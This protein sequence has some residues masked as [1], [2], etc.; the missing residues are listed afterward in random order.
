MRPFAGFYFILRY[1]LIVLHVVSHTVILTP[2]IYASLTLSTSAVVIA[3]TKPYKKEYMNVLDTLLLSL[4][5]GIFHLLSTDYTYARGILFTVAGLTP[6]IVFWISLFL[7][8]IYKMIQKYTTS[9]N[10]T[11]EVA[12]Y[13]SI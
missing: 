2:L 8:I 10:I 5:S 7:I 12:R 9:W 6:A 3:L 4:L 11:R 13:G 1:I